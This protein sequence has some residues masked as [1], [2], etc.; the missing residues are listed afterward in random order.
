MIGSDKETYSKRGLGTCNQEDLLARTG[1]NA[2]N[3]AYEDDENS[4]DP[5]VKMII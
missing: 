1:N 2:P 3:V 4:S 5:E